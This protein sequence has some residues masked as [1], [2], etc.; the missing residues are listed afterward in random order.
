MD[1]RSLLPG[2]GRSQQATPVNPVREDGL[3]VLFAHRSASFPRPCVRLILFLF[4][5]LWRAKCSRYW[6][7]ISKFTMSPS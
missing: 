2:A 6:L 3:R 5:S 7:T 4:N 1:S